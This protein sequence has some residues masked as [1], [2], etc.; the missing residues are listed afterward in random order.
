LRSALR[1]RASSLLTLLL[2]SGCGYPGGQVSAHQVPLG[3]GDV[4]IVEREESGLLF[5]P[6]AYYVVESRT[7]ASS[8]WRNVLTFR[9]DDQTGISERAVTVLNEQTAFVILGWMYAVTTDGGEHWTAWDAKVDLDGW[10]CCNFGLIQRVELMPDG[11]GVMHLKVID[12]GRGEVPMLV[13][14]DFGRTW[15]RPVSNRRS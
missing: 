7:S 13:T 9:Q 5:V 12:P 3:P 4:R 6:G 8:R 2:A 14:T 15:V 11:T 10:Q 1:T